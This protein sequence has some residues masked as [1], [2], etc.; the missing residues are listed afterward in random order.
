MFVW[1]V[2][3]INN[4]SLG[5]SVLS[6][7]EFL[8]SDQKP[9]LLICVEAPQTGKLF[10]LRLQ[11]NMLSSYFVVHSGDFVCIANKNLFTRPTAESVST[12]KSW[13]KSK[14]TY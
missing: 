4:E 12:P 2:R 10:W 6:D 14:T 13:S 11:L 8:L 3:G 7:I 5:S 9:D 1:N